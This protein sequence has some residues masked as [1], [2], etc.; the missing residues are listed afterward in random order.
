[1]HPRIR[2]LTLLTRVAV[3]LGLLIGPAAPAAAQDD[4]LAP[5]V[6]NWERHGF[7]IEVGDDGSTNAIWRVY[8]WCG[9]GVPEPCD[10]IV[11][12]RIIS[13]GR[14]TIQ[15]TGAD[16]SGAFQGEV[17]DTTDPELLD[18]GPLTLTPQPYDMALIEQGDTQLVLCGDDSVN[19]AP[20]DVLAQ[21]GA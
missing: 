8:S 10:Q 11:E 17:L 19:Q 9:P 2:L 4:A 16:D 14:A 5:I 21:C 6:G 13:G 18:V 20:P 12:N 1:M 3:G 7:G 15:F